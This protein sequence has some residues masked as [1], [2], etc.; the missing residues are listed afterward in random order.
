MSRVADSIQ[1]KSGTP[2]PSTNSGTTTTTAS[3]SATAAAVSVVARS[4]PASTAC[5]SLTSRSASPGN[6]A[7]PL[8]TDFTV[9]SEM[10]APITVWPLDANWTASGSPILPRATTQIFILV[11]FLL[12]AM[13]ADQSPS[14]RRY[15]EFSTSA[16]AAQVQPSSRPGLSYA[17]RY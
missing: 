17:D 12:G 5:L 7:T 1:P 13:R 15:T 2:S 4:R 10:S 6:G 14:T 9:G 3:D 16:C 8:L 11:F